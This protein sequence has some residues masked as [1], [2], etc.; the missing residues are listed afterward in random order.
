MKNDHPV[1]PY[2]LL[3]LASC[4]WAGNIVLG[5][6]VHGEILPLALAF[7]RWSV[8]FVVLVPLTYASFRRDF[9][10]IQR[11]WKWLTL[12]TAT[13]VVL[14]HSLLYT[15][16]TS[17][18]ALNAGLMMAT[19]PIIIPAIAYLIHR[20]KLT[21]MQGLGLVA[22]VF[23]VGIIITQG[24]LAVL[25]S[26]TFTPG[27]LWV[28]TA[29]PLW[30]VYSVVL[31]DRPTGLSSRA[32]MFCI[33]GL[34]S[35]MLIPFYMWE[36]SNYG[37]FDLNA[38]NLLTIVYIS[39]VASVVAYFAWNKGVADVGAIKAGPFLHVIPACTALLAIVFLGEVLQPFHF[40]GIALIVFGIVLTT[41][42]RKPTS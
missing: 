11:H 41:W 25:S 4:T 42:K 1:L 37:G 9:P 36:F 18:T 30:G 8:A 29:V 22:S 7:F 31:K 12:V 3:I 19:S 6:A 10:V 5:R 27:D 32:L 17:T 14:F 21:K 39:V 15:G 26:L 33:T 23:G 20:D 28:L 16:L 40:P 35:I 13:G 24:D 2:L 34:G 38:P